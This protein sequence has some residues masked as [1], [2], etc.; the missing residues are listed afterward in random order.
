MLSVVPPMS[1]GSPRGE[2]SQSFR[3]QKSAMINQE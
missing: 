2:L 3:L 1:F